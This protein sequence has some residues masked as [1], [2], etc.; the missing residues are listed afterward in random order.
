MR[1]CN[2]GCCNDNELDDFDGDD[3]MSDEFDG[4]GEDTIPCPYCAVE[5]YED[6]EVCPHCGSYIMEENRP[7]CPAWVLWTALILLALIL[8]GFTQLL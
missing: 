1:H 3:A 8:S 2:R 6:A 7:S 5:I 4:E